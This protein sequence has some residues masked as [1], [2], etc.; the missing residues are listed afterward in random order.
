[1]KKYLPMTASKNVAMNVITIYIRAVI[2]NISTDRNVSE[3]ILNAL[4]VNS[5]TPNMA[6]IDVPNVIMI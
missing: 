4:P 6:A 1:M 3:L 2:E 5:S